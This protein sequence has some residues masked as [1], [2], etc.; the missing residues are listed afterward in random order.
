MKRVLAAL[1][2]SLTVASAHAA[3]F[4]PL[5]RK[6]VLEASLP[7][8]NPPVKIVRGASI[9]FAPG[10]PTGLHRHPA[11]T[12]GVVTS[13]TIAFQPDG[14]AVRMLHAGDSFFEPA[15]HLIDRFDNASATDPASITVFYLTDSPSRPLIDMVGGK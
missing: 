3:S 12:V 13:G 2:L 1:C 9:T 14:E 4:P 8:A 6:S 10:Q 15:G 11:S 7:A 5:E